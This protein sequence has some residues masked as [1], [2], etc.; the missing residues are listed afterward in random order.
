MKQYLEIGKVNN[1]HGL[2]GEVKLEMWCDNIDYIKQFDTLY[3]D[4]EGKEALTLVSARAQKNIAI[5]KFAEIQN[6]DEAQML[7]N[8]LIY[9]NRDDAKIQEG[10]YYLADIIG[11]YVVDIDTDEEYGKIVDVLNYGSCDIYD[12]ESWGRHTLIPAIDDVVKEINTEYQI[13]KIKA[14]KGLFDED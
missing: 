1:T 11:C 2:K 13:V 10:S 12:V 3:L 6:I 8:K 7:K 9:G 14:M 4:D 5:L